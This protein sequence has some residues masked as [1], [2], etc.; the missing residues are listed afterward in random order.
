MD[1]SWMAFWG[2]PCLP[3]VLTSLIAGVGVTLITPASSISR[4]EA[5]AMITRERESRP[6]MPPLPI[7]KRKASEG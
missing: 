3:S 2:N 6:D 5:L 7:G 1:S 4:E